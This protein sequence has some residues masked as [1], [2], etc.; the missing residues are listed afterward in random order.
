MESGRNR[1]VF[2]KNDSKPP[3]SVP[4][5]R[6]WKTTLRRILKVGM[7]FEFNLPESTG[8]CEGDNE[9]CPCVYLQEDSCWKQCL[10]YEDCEAVAHKSRCKNVTAK[11]KPDACAACDEYKFDCPE[12]FCTAFA[13]GCIN[14]G[15]FVRSC[16][17]CDYRFDEKHNPEHIRSTVTSELKPSNSYGNINKSGVHSVVTDGSLLGN[18][19]MEIITTGRRIDFAEFYIMSKRIIDKSVSRGAY[20]NERCSIHMHLLASYYANLVGGKDNHMGVPNMVSELER[21][22][23]QIILANYHQLARRYQNAITWMTMGLDEPDRMTRWERYR[24]SNLGISA[25]ANSMSSVQHQSSENAGGNKYAWSN[26][27]YTKFDKGGDI[28]QM[29]LEMRVCDCLLS[30]SAVAAIACMF[31]AMMIKAVEISRY[32]VLEIG[33][34]A[35]MKQAKKV[36]EVVLNNRK[37]WKENDRFGDTSNLPKYQDVLIRESLELVRQLKHILI[38]VGPAYSILEQLA[39]KPCA[40]R[41]CDGEKWEDIEKT[42]EVVMEEE[43]LLDGVLGQY[44]D[45]RLVEKCKDLD[46]WIKEVGKALGNEP[47]DLPGDVEKSVNDYIKDK[48]SNGEVLWSDTLGAVV[49]VN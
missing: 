18:K 5:V 9:H 33:N 11:C 21:S 48:S 17:G 12:Q 34:D 46:E 25:V 13:S 23:P 28:R 40:L 3:L 15:G 45:L 7:E 20:V 39:E 27:N 2:F 22:M 19:G 29:H 37:A 24:V 31:Y 6:Y 4:D 8:N 41:L 42:L 36:K 16:Q 38:D 44:I 26:Y 32:G 30:P 49:R 14:C 47:L 35:W 10:K 43:S 1:W